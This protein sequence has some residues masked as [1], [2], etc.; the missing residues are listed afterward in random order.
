MFLR[1]VI[2]N[3]GL[4]EIQ[5]HMGRAEQSAFTAKTVIMRAVENFEQSLP[6]AASLVEQRGRLAVLI[7]GGQVEKTKS[8]VP[9]VQWGESVRIPGS[10]QRVL[11][12][13]KKDG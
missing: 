4:K 9:S 3:L 6:V 11:L 10:E 13:G 2:R 12:V 1:E 5:V 8:L 7:G